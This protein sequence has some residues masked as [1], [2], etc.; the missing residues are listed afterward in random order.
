MAH[1]TETDIGAVGD[2]AGRIAT[3]LE[4]RGI[5]AGA[6]GAAGNIAGIIAAGLEL[7]EFGAD[8]EITG[9]ENDAI[10]AYL[11]SSGGL[12]GDI[13]KIPGAGAI[14]G[15]GANLAGV[16]L[17]VSEGNYLE[18]ANALSE[19]ALQGAFAGL[20]ARLFG[21]RGADIGAEFG[22]LLQDAAS[23]LGE[24]IA[25][26]LFPIDL[27]FPIDPPGATTNPIVIP[28]TGSSVFYE[29]GL[30]LFSNGRPF[31]PGPGY[32]HFST[33]ADETFAGHPGETDVFVF[34]FAGQDGTPNPIGNDTILNSEFLDTILLINGP[35]L[36]GSLLNDSTVVETFFDF[37]FNP[38]GQ[39]TYDGNVGRDFF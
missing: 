23:A 36:A 33:S 7:S 15:V 14:S 17:Q 32:Y 4:F 11:E 30:D 35:V 34:D 18:A 5:D 22:G 24:R 26:E 19:A 39:I 12:V 37:Q 25:D 27:P 29:N 9:A 8:G 3:G 13:A 31:N 6:L 20:G 1:L 38:L 10:V 21:Q 28:P 16:A 2:L